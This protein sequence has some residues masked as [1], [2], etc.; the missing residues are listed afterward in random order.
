MVSPL[1]PVKHLRAMHGV[2]VGGVFPDLK[3]VASFGVLRGCDLAMKNAKE[4]WYIDHGYFGEGRYRI[5]RGATI[6]SGEGD[7]SWDRFNSFNH[8]MQDWSTGGEHVVLCPPSVPQ[9]KFLNIKNWMD[10][11]IKKVRQYTDRKIIISQK[12]NSPE[13]FYEKGYDDLQNIPIDE[14]LKKAWVLVTDHSNTMTTALIRGV[15]IICTNINRSIGSF[16]RIEEPRYNRE[17]LK[18]IAY[19][20][21]TLRDIESGKAWEELNL[22]G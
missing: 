10:D 16:E 3:R 8:E 5:T 9:I 19:N 2:E 13:G 4:F 17:W 18:N 11:T 20:Q 7:M 21:W 12:P 15:P 1:K 6:H 22:W 14:A